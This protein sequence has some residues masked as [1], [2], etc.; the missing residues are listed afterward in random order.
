MDNVTSESVC[1]SLLLQRAYDHETRP[2]DSDSLRWAGPAALPT[3]DDRP[4]DSQKY[5]QSSLGCSWG[6][7]SDRRDYYHSVATP[8]GKLSSPRCVLM[9]RVFNVSLFFVFVIM[10]FFMF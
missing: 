3:G 2:T 9:L 8:T 5:P 1:A 7:G 6:E 10:V 4:G